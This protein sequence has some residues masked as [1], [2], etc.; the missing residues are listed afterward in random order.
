MRPDLG[1]LS[2]PLAPPQPRYAAMR[3]V[4]SPVA[5][6]ADV[7]PENCGDL[8]GLPPFQRQQN[9]PCPIRFTALLRF[10]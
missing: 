5:Y 7:Y 3:E 9:C 1:L 10:R 2:W 8:L 6:R 4:P